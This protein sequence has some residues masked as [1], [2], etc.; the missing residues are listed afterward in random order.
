MSSEPAARLHS[1]RAI[2]AWLVGGATVLLVAAALVLSGL[3][4]ARSGSPLTI[5]IDGHRR[6]VHTRAA[7]VGAA[8]RGAGIDLYPEDRVSPD[9]TTPLV[10]GLDVH[11]KRAVPVA[12]HA[13][14]TTQQLRTHA[15]TVGAALAE[16]GV[17]VGPHDEIWLGERQTR[18]DAP[19]FGDALA[20]LH[21]SSRA[22]QRSVPYGSAPLLFVHRATSLLLNDDG[23][24]S[25]LYTTGWTVG[26]ALEEQGVSLYAG[27]LVEPDLQTRVVEG[28]VISIQRSVPI[29]IEVDGRT[30]HT[31]TRAETVSGA[32]AGERIALV[33][34]DEVAPP[35]S[36][37]IR[38]GMT[39]RVT[40]VRE[41]LVIEFDPI[42]YKTV[43]VPDPELE[44]DQMRLVQ[45]GQEGLNKRRYRIVYRDGQETNRFLEDSWAEQVP[46][47]KT[48][49]YGTEIIV[50]T[51]DTPDGPVE[52]WRK[53]RVYTTSYKPSSCGKPKDHPRYGYTR[54][55]IL[56]R[57]GI[58]AVDPTVIPLRTLMYVPGYGLARAA[59][60]GG[61]VKGK[62][63]DLGFSDTDYESWHWWTDIYLLTP[64]PPRHTIRWILPDWPKFPDRRR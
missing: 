50:R 40:R 5:H 58:V 38:P 16:L 48:I 7:T 2:P 35:L 54:L 41:A 45:A 39:V 30:V 4:L 3:G 52:Y 10:P 32:L 37:T 18:L 19:L 51:L 49:A 22:T 6:T 11:V 31:R 43:T 21:P 47:T 53:I 55:G 25:T 28:L 26:Q 29:R 23:E 1:P 60:T 44:I 8:L 20:S 56:L 9:L 61:G 57:R 59:D 36:S 17:G 12:V 24:T 62:F 42:P 15:T 46:V 34:K 33:G 64:V 63:V 27:D 13:D 14:G